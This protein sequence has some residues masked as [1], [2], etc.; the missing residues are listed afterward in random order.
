VLGALA[1]RFLPRKVVTW[2]PSVVSIGLAFTVQ[3]YT[4]LAFL[5]G[6]VLMAVA[7]KLSPQQTAK[8]GIVICAG[9][10]AGESLAGVGDA[11]INMAKA[12]SAG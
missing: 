9:I 11:L 2:M 1:E 7:Q 12:I 6:A 5:V 8:Y 3:V 4:S 10:I